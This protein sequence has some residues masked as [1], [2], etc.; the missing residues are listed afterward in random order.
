[1]QQYIVN[2][3]L[4]LDKECYF[5]LRHYIQKHCSVGMWLKMRYWPLHC[6]LEITVVILTFYILGDIFHNS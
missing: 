5:T 4:T 3:E 6:T 2:S 1:M